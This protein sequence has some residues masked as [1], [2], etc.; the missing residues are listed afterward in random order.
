MRRFFTEPQ[1][2]SEG[3]LYIY[4]DAKH[5]EKVLRMKI[6]DMVL[7]F[8][9]TGFEYTAEL[10]EVGKT[11]CR[12]RI[13]DKTLSL[14]EPTVKVSLF[15]GIP[16]SGKMEG[17]VQKAV[18]LG[19]YEIIPV[20][21]ER[22]V[23]RIND[24]ASGVEKAKRWRRV[25]IE[26]V[27][28]CG[29]GL[30]PFVHEPIGFE[31]A[32]ERLCSVELAIMPYEALGHEGKHGLGELLAS[33]E[34]HANIGIMVGPEGGFSDAEAEFAMSR[35]VHAVGLGRRILRTET[36]ASALIPVIMFA[37]GEF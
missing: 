2:V 24:A 25:A 26:A 17:I 29:R 6:G 22:S 19:V 30:V 4:E 28:Q 15:Q 37:K 34:E 31:K 16:K 13:I 1:N 32:V 23:V 20:C 35:G 3:E 8:D 9:G 14:S 36:V 12:A 18:E 21:M 10:V 5:I 7:V 11:A 33:N 27:K